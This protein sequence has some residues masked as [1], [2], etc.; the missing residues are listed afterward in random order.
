MVFFCHFE[1]LIQAQNLC[2]ALLKNKGL[3]K[4]L[5][6]TEQKRTK[7]DQDATADL[8]R[9]HVEIKLAT[10]RLRGLI[11][12]FGWPSLVLGIHSLPAQTGVTLFCKETPDSKISGA[13][14][15]HH[16]PLLALVI[17]SLKFAN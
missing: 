9:Q 15:N 7:L 12:Q 3:G 6:K 14:I 1:S 13:K 4:P 8:V 5:E 11:G 2:K 16:S 10:K 17:S